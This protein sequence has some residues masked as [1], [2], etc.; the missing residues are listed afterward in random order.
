MPASTTR[1]MV[2][3]GGMLLPG[4]VALSGGVAL[5]DGTVAWGLMPGLSPGDGV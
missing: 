3:S 1:A 4:G 5:C 2:A